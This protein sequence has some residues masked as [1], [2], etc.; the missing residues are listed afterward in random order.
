MLLI[1][2]AE[3]QAR[4]QFAQ[5]ES[6][7]LLPAWASAE[8]WV[9]KRVRPFNTPIE[10]VPADVQEAVALMTARYLARETSPD[11]TLSMGDAVAYLPKLDRDVESLIGPYRPM[12]FG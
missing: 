8:A 3:L 6:A 10:L 5:V 1:T 7:R 12:V 2:L 11:G 9:A 4:P